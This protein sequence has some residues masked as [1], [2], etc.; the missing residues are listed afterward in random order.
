MV[1]LDTTKMKPNNPGLSYVTPQALPGKFSNLGA[2]AKMTDILVQSAVA[3]D[4]RLTIDQADTL[5]KQLGS[6]YETSSI[7]GTQNLLRDKENLED[8]LETD[9][10][11]EEIQAKLDAVTQKYEIAKEQGVISSYEY[12]RRILKDTQDLANANP[13]YQDEIAARVNKTLN[14]IG[15]LDLLKR[16]A[17]LLKV[18][19][20][21]EIKE[22]AAIKKY[23]TD[24]KKRNTL[25]MSR[26]VILATYTKELYED[27]L[28][29]G[30]IQILSDNNLDDKVKRTQARENIEL[31]GGPAKATNG[32][33]KTLLLEL[34]NVSSRLAR[35][36][37]NIKEAGVIR[38]N[39]LIYANMHLNNFAT[40]VGDDKSY[41]KAYENTKI[42][43][44]K[45]EKNTLSRMS[46][47]DSKVYLENLQSI[48]DSKALFNFEEKS[49]LN[50]KMM[51]VQ[52]ELIK[53]YDGFVKN[54]NVSLSEQQSNM[55]INN[56]MMITTNPN[57][58][59]M[60]LKGFKERPDVVIKNSLLF[61][62]V[63][64]TQIDQ[65]TDVA[66]QPEAFGVMNNLFSTVKSQDNA[67]TKYT[68]AKQLLSTINGD[69]Y[70]RTLPYMMGINS[71]GSQWQQDLPETLDYFRSATHN[72]MKILGH[73]KNTFYVQDGRI[74]SKV[75]VNQAR[76]MAESMTITMQLLAKVQ[77]NDK[78][79]D[80]D[81][82]EFLDK[83]LGAK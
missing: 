38:D 58:S 83:M 69:A 7:T 32:M 61:N 18:Q 64:E 6:E 13:A 68:T 28:R 44:E 49:G 66:Q 65:G 72:N 34:E 62:E 71:S 73:T 46:G 22:F 12:E 67:N 19:Q 35:G 80:E 77:G 16:D 20:D 47:A 63:L 27:R 45:I 36:E 39:T 41:Q 3:L 43:L 2:A 17:A 24:K 4:K 52:S 30:A 23:L 9:P 5:A 25:G 55:L 75:G 76:E 56:Y 15:T 37:I 31:Q 50:V 57:A 60:N 53:A 21:A 33:V 78:L 14:N 82:N 51:G 70:K 81:A 54:L 10:K 29:E 48:E 11:N 26:E 40:I 1:K 8:Q 74:L 59:G 42:I 79:K